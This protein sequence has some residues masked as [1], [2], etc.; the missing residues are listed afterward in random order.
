MK[1][2]DTL[3]PRQRDVL[4]LRLRGHG[5]KRVSTELG[6]SEHTVKDHAKVMLLKLRAKDMTAAALVAMREGLIE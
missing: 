5:L 4:M 2:T 1:L 6:I 3:S